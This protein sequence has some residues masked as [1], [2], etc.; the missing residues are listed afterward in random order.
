MTSEPFVRVVATPHFNR[1]FKRLRKKYRQIES[2]LRPLIHQLE[3]GATPGDQIQRVQFTVY[4]VR[5]PNSDSKRGK[6]GGY[7]VIY[8]LKT[9]NFIFLVDIYPKSERENVSED[10]LRHLIEAVEAEHSEN[11]E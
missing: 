5:L 9:T 3:Q 7:R 10:E 2:D 8:Y 4:K 6:S 11:D 1:T